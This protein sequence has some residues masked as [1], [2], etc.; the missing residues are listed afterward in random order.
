VTRRLVLAGLTAALATGQLPPPRLVPLLGGH[1]LVREW[2]IQYRAHD[3]LL[4]RAYVLLPRWYGPRRDPALPLVVSP[5]GRG[6][7]ARVNAK[8]WGNLP[9]LGRF[10]VVNP[11]GQG[12]R[13]ALYSWGDPGEIA[14]LARMPRVVTHALPWLRI[15]RRHVYAVGG[16]MG[17]QETLLLVARYPRVFAGAAAFDAPTSLAARYEAFRFLPFGIDVQRLARVEVGGTP[18]RDP[19]AWAIRSPLDWARQ[20]ARSH[21]P[22][23]LWWSRRD[24]I[25]V[26]QARQSGALYR[27]VKRWNPAAPVVEY[28][29]DW[30]HSAEFKATRRLPFAL[31]RLGL[32]PPYHPLKNR[33]AALPRAA[34]G[35]RSGFRPRT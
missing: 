17:G 26:D 1:R 29:G 30:A 35:R 18:S 12:R 13:L 21:V 5:H 27:A 20:I 7:P 25:V 10:A 23:E 2:T 16:S 9:A 15:E 28:V 8:L 14:D 33:A 31:A 4:R 6:V 34:R 32:M 3:G 24:R 19:H 22:L 11:E